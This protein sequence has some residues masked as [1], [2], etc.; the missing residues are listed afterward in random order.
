MDIQEIR[1]IIDLFRRAGLARL[2]IVDGDKSLCLVSR[3][4]D[5]G[6]ADTDRPAAGIRRPSDGGRASMPAA[7]AAAAA[8]A[9]YVVKS[10]TFGTFFRSTKP[11]EKPLVE[12]GQEVAEGAVVCIVE[13][14]KVLNNIEALQ[15]GVV[16]DIL[17]ADGQSV[18]AGQPLMVI[19]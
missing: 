16:R 5:T 9:S 8:V 4:E 19:Q 15:A 14:M 6:K 17:V 2:E 10:P 11:G 1:S 13:A 12:A 7:P 18:E 3:S